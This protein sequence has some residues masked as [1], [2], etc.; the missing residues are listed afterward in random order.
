MTVKCVGGIV[1]CLYQRQE[2]MSPASHSQPLHNPQ[3]SILCSYNILE[4]CSVI[5]VFLGRQIIAR[6]EAEMIPTCVFYISVGIK[7]QGRRYSDKS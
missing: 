1:C 6:I 3:T 2:V 7:Q 5:S 4:Q